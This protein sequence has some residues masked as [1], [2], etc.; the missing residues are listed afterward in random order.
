[1]HADARGIVDFGAAGQKAGSLER[2]PRCCCFRNP[3][4]LFQ[5]SV[6]A[7]D[8]VKLLPPGCRRSLQAAAFLVDAQS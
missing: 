4:L 6:G 8:R 3:S 7:F 2:G 5:L 1:M